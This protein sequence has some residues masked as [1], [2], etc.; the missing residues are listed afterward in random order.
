M[1]KILKEGLTFDDVLLIP[2]YSEVLP[3]QVDLSTK[4]CE[5]IQLNIPLLSA[6]MDT[7]TEF[8]LAIAMA[9]EGG[10]GMIHKNMSIEQQADNVDKVKRS[11]NG[12]IINPFSL[13]PEHTLED[14][15]NLMRRFKISGVPITV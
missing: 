5:G 12:V 15:N 9:R 4:L 3:Y 6:S 2:Q 13:S 7:V 11:E 10:I 8:Q 14:A 1:A